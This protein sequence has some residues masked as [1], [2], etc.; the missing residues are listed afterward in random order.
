MWNSFFGNGRK[1]SE[2]EPNKYMRAYIISGC[3]IILALSSL[4]WYAQWEM[5][6]GVYLGYGVVIGSFIF[7]KGIGRC[8]ADQWSLPPR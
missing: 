5:T 1:F 3:A 2:L 6:T 4:F 7:A 8:I